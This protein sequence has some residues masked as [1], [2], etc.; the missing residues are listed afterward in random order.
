MSRLSLCLKFQQH[1]IHS[2]RPSFYLSLQTTRRVWRRKV[3]LLVNGWLILSWTKLQPERQSGRQKDKF[4]TTKFYFSI[5][6][7]THIGTHTH[8]IRSLRLAPV[9]YKIADDARETNLPPHSSRNPLKQSPSF[10]PH[11][12]LN[13][14][15]Q[16]LFCFENYWKPSLFLARSTEK[17]HNSMSSSSSSSVR[18]RHALAHT[19][20][21]PHTYWSK[22]TFFVPKFREK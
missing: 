6:I 9:G 5:Y 19:L 17:N 8:Q 18:G 16:G 15:T 11:P 1:P 2:R 3:G 7:H 20:A 14:K 4:P 12:R 10:R 21:L 13:Q 22:F